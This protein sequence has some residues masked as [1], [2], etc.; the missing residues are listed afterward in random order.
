MVVTALL[1]LYRL[2][3]NERD[4]HDLF[5]GTKLF[6]VLRPKSLLDG[7]LNLHVSL[8]K[9]LQLDCLLDNVLELGHFSLDTVLSVA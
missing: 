7:L 8:D 1:L 9:P 2:V 3:K 4:C 6:H 5:T